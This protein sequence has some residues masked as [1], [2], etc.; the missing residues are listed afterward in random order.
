M[1]YTVVGTTEPSEIVAGD[2]ASWKILTDNSDFYASTSFSLSYSIRG[3]AGSKDIS[4]SADGDYHLIELTATVTATWP[5]GDYFLDAYVSDGA[6]ERYTLY[7]KELKVKTNLAAISLTGATD[8]LYDGRSFAKRIVDAVDQTILGN[9]TDDAQTMQAE[10]TMIIHMSL[11]QKQRVRS[12]YY[13]IYLDEEN[14]KKAALGEY[15]SHSLFA[16]FT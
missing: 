5:A 14:L 16:E 10:G 13:A 7:S 4:S 3:L 12:N 15:P 9:I 11:D 1:P 6:N 8:A 2:S